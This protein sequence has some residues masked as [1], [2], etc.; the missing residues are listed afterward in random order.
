[1]ST[2]ISNMHNY[3]KN[4]QKNVGLI[5]Y[6]KATGNLVKIVRVWAEP[7]SNDIL[8]NF[9]RSPKKEESHKYE[10]ELIGPGVGIKYTGQHDFFAP[11]YSFCYIHDFVPHSNQQL[12][13]VLY[14]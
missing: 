3:N 14:E 2:I 13:K 7:I 5:G 9:S 10:V 8:E 11:L 6:D 1:M 4:L 12:V